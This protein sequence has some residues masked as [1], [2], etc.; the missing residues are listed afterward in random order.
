MDGIGTE[1]IAK[2]LYKL[3]PQKN[4]QFILW[5]SPDCPASHLRI[6]DK[7]FRRHTFT[8]WPDAM[9]YIPEYSKDLIEIVSN[10]SP[11]LWVEQSA[12]AARFGHIDAIAT[13]PL[14]KTS[15]KKAGLKDIGHTDILKRI[16]GV[17]NA[18][19]GFV[20]THFSVVLA[21]GHLPMQKVAKEWN[22]E[23]LS[24]A[25]SAAKELRDLLSKREQK[26]PIA[27][28]GLNPHAGEDGLF[29]NDL[30][31]FKEATKKH[32][33]TDF[34]GPLVPDVAFQPDV[35]GKHA[36]Y[37]CAYHDQGL[38]PFK[39]LH[40]RESGVHISLGLPFVRTS[41]DHGT[42]KDIFGKNKADYRSM[43]EALEWAISLAKKR[44]A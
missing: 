37:V 21:T 14:S 13:A 31:V 43:F 34:S 24:E 8:S 42:A 7:V 10:Q 5:R 36:I 32:K 27:I 15:I 6:I 11:A 12:Q 35:R 28:L 40:G 39:M 17:E 18:Y 1:V 26:K 25:I 44:K 22:A 20:G 19:M 38:I 16:A 30:E 4:I 29:G 23:N 2:A 41:V 3:K 33:N 9:G